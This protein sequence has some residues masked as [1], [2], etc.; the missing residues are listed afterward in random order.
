M[1]IKLMPAKAFFTKTWPAAMSG[2][3][4]SASTLSASAAPGSRTTAAF[5]TLGTLN[6]RDDARRAVMRDASL[7]ASMVPARARRS[8]LSRGRVD[9]VKS[10]RFA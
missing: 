7:N 10:R 2:T 1:S 8:A 4:K 5:M 9:G 6:L 3:G